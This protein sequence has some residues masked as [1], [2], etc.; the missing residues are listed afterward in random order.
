MPQGKA[1]LRTPVVSAVWTCDETTS[2]QLDAKCQNLVT[3]CFERSLIIAD[4]PNMIYVNR[5]LMRLAFN[6]SPITLTISRFENLEAEL[7][8]KYVRGSD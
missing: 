2:Y 4:D 5:K 8:I 3:R 7:F 1:N 6:V